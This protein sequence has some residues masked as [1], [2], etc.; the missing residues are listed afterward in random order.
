VTFK[1]PPP[2]MASDGDWFA[3]WASA[4]PWKTVIYPNTTENDYQI[5]LFMQSAGRWIHAF[6]YNRPYIPTALDV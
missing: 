4:I 1:R 6:Y 3:R 2:G 5:F